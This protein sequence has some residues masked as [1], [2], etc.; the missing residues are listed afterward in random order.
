M[1]DY[2]DKVVLI[3][4]ATGDLGPTVVAAFQNAGARLVL[5]D[6]S[7]GRLAEMYPELA[8]SDKHFMAEEVDLTEPETVKNMTEQ[9]A[10]KL[11][12]IDVLVNIAGGFRM[13]SFS[14]EDALESFDYMHNLNAR[15]NFIAV[16]SVL[17]HMLEGGG[18]K[19]VS[20]AA[21]G[22][23]SGGS[24]LAGYSAAKAA[25]LRITESVA[26][27]FKDKGIYAN[28]VLP[29]TIDTPSNRES[30]PNADPSKWLSPAEIAD[31]ILF[32]A[33]DASRAI[34]GVGIPL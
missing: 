33:S 13:K 28:A 6:R 14:A 24:R 21:R 18:G 23:L 20:V 16:H 12:R 4:G 34:N 2:T 17:P 9:A 1:I 8:A 22:A 7:K 5:V 27:E 26:A 31:V 10:G 3:T 25:V 30:M 11:G 32:L 29:S 19:I 15:T